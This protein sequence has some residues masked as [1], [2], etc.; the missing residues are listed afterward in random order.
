M[1][2]LEFDGDKSE[3]ARNTY[4]TKQ[5]F[6]PYIPGLTHTLV[7]RENALDR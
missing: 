2:Y 7:T 6:Y 4:S 3:D 5:H 1:H